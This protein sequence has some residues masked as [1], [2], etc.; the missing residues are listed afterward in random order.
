MCYSEHL[1]QSPPHF[2]VSRLALRPFT[3]KL[4]PIAFIGPI[5]CL[6]HYHTYGPWFHDWP[7]VDRVLH[8]L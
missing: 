7:T 2:T 8:A 4:I 3:S 5:G 1:P 6:E